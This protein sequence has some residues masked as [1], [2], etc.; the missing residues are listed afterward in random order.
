MLNLHLILQTG[1]V[2]CLFFVAPTAFAAETTK[3]KTVSTYATRQMSQRI[4]RFMVGLNQLHPAWLNHPELMALHW[5]GLPSP[6][7]RKF[8]T[9][10][11][12]IENPQQA[13]VIVTQGGVLDDA[14]AG[15]KYVFSFKRVG[16]YWSLINVQESWRCHRTGHSELYQLKPCP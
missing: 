11:S 10:L 15:S 3:D 2:A 13:Q 7:Y 12:P 16:A 8:S 9:T 4:S 14:V 1:L 5:V 6:A